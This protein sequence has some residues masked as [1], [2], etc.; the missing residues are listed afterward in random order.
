MRAK[1]C[2]RRCEAG[3]LRSLRQARPNKKAERR[4][5]QCGVV[6][7]ENHDI[8]CR[9][10]ACGAEEEEEGQADYVCWRAGPGPR[11]GRLAAA[12]RRRAP[13]RRVAAVERSAETKARKRAAENQRPRPPRRSRAASSSEK[14][15]GRRSGSPRPSLGSRRS[16][17]SSRGGRAPTR[18]AT[19]RAT[20][21]RAASVKGTRAP[22]N[23][24]RP[25]D[26]GHQYGL[27]DVA[28][29]HGREGL[30]GGPGLAGGLDFLPDACVG[31]G[32]I[33]P[34]GYEGQKEAGNL[35]GYRS[36]WAGSAPSRTRTRPLPS[37]ECSETH[38]KLEESILDFVHK[39]KPDPASP[40]AGANAKKLASDAARSWLKANDETSDTLETFSRDCATDDWTDATCG[41]C[42]ASLVRGLRSTRA[43]RRGGG[44]CRLPA[45]V[46][47]RDARHGT[48]VH[49]RG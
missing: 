13:R 9:R 5:K 31:A 17:R 34:S 2:F 1:E 28:A 26:R 10:R 49:A 7:R 3:I 33:K 43:R 37:L 44:A 45:H 15:A 22:T 47:R 30:R 25:R 36:F 12:A 40:Y 27:H 38:Q 42:A 11:R 8:G 48:R 46:R 21:G 18:G 19:R 39:A 29:A 23:T 16:P 35:F 32:R 14:S 41:L 4:L 20:S 6:P 24:T